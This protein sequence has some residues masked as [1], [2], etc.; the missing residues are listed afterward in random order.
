MAHD[1]LIL[2]LTALFIET[3]ENHHKAFM[4][5]NGVDPE[6]PLWYANYLHSRLGE[7]LN[8]EFTKSEIIYLLVMLDKKRAAEAV[9]ENWTLY[10]AKYLIDNYN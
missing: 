1:K 6:W 2:D 3:G 4:E 8:I 9:E 5:S 10:N 7:L